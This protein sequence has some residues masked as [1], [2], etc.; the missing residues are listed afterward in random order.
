GA[1]A[2]QEAA[3]ALEPPDAAAG[4]DVDHFELS[5]GELPGPAHGVP[6]VRVAAVDDDVAGTETRA[7]IGE[8][9]LRD[10]AGGNHQPD[11][12]PGLELLH[13]PAERGRRIGAFPGERRDLVGIAIRDHATVAALQQPAHHVGA[14]SA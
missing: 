13:P 6:V 11:H 4:P 12:P 14:H 2:D 1:A 5:A 9:F 7:K 8:T 3:A 10:V